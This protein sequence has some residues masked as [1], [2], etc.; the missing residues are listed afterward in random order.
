MNNGLLDGPSALCYA[1]LFQENISLINYCRTWISLK[2]QYF[3]ML[4][5][6]LS[7]VLMGAE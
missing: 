3:M 2:D 4:M 5:K 6:Q 7:V 1:I